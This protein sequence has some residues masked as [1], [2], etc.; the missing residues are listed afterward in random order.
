MSSDNAALT[1]FL[2]DAM[3]HEDC[4]NVILEYQAEQ[5]RIADELEAMKPWKQELKGK[6]V[7]FVY[8]TSPSS[9]LKT[10]QEMMV[11]T[12]LRRP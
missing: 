1:N 12:P 10:W 11:L 5:K 7:Q 9:P 4:K 2:R 6:N 8:I 3:K